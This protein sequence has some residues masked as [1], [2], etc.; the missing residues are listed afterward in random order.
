MS[1]IINA[2]FSIMNAKQG[3]KFYQPITRSHSRNWRTSKTYWPVQYC[4]RHRA[5]VQI[6]QKCPQWDFSSAPESPFG[7]ACSCALEHGH[8]VYLNI[9]TSSLGIGPPVLK[10]TAYKALHFRTF[11]MRLFTANEIRII[12]QDKTNRTKHWASNLVYS[13]CKGTRLYWT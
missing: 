3:N 10:T 2:M 7:F 12:L 9:N 13:F 6:L 8:R 4:Q 5:Q 11:V 1:W